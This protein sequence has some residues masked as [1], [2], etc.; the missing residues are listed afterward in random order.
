M[1][2]IDYENLFIYMS[3][4]FAF[5]I[6]IILLYGCAFANTQSQIYEN[7]LNEDDKGDVKSQVLAILTD[8]ETKDTTS[9]E[10]KTKITDAI[11][12][13]N[14]NNISVAELKKIID[15]LKDMTP[16]KR[17]AAIRPAAI[18]PAAMRPAAD[19]TD[20]TA[21]K[22]AAKDASTPTSTTS[23]DATKDAATDAADAASTT[24]TKL[25]TS[26]ATPTKAPTAP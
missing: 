24:P 19:A 16:T 10:N 11:E 9:A 18:R 22:D 26:T 2:D 15:L 7:F 8:A 20:A 23:A 6:F 4:I 1:K 25:P 21:A 12:K 3:L 5:C 13:I 17:P 14:N